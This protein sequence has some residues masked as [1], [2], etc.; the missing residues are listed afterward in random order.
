MPKSED[1]LKFFPKIDEESH[2]SRP[3]LCLEAYYTYYKRSRKFNE[4]CYQLTRSMYTPELV[5]KVMV[6]YNEVQDLAKNTSE[7]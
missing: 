3:R 4:I 1:V 5:S 6:D 2:R 7:R